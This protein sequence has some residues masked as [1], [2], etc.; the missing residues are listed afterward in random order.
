MFSITTSNPHLQLMLAEPEYSEALFALVDSNRDYLKTWLP[1]LD[2]NTTVQDS[3]DFLRHCLKNYFSKT[4]LVTLLMVD[5]KL[6]GTAGFNS[7]NRLNCE[8]EIGYWLDQKNMGNGYVTTAV[9]KII[10]IGFNQY[11]LNR[12]IIRVASGNHSSRAIA[13]R[14]GFQFEGIARQAAS[15]YETFVDLEIYSL[16]KRDW[17][18]HA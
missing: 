6:V 3:E 4:S 13:K 18:S 2:N 14:L 12:Q 10:E 5:D 9:Q 17:Q 16:L 7:I 1:W 11:K 8:A 15:L